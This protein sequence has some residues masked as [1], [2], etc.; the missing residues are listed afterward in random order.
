VLG[1]APFFLIA[2]VAMPPIP[3]ADPQG[4]SQ[5][6]S[7]ERLAHLA[8]GPTANVELCRVLAGEH[9]GTLVAVKRLRPMLADDPDFIAMFRDEMWLASMLRHP[10]IAQVLGWGEDTQGLYLAVEFVR[11]VSLQR[12][13]RTV[14]V[15]GEAFTE[16]LVVYIAAC[17]CAGL[18][19]AHELRSDAGEHLNLVHRDLTPGNL[20]LGFDGEVKITDFGLAKAKQRITQTEVGITK[21]EPQY[22]SP[23]QVRGMPLDGRSDLFALGVVLYELFAQRRPWTVRNVR[24]AL[25]HI[26]RGDAPD[27]A[28]LAPRVDPSLVTLVKRCM[29]KEAD[30]RPASATE[31]L[32]ELEQWLRLHG[33]EKSR[34]SLARFVR[35]NALKQMRW[36]ERAIA[37]DLTGSDE[38]SPFDASRAEAAVISVPDSESNVEI[39]EVTRSTATGRAAVAEPFIADDSVITTM[40]RQAP[41]SVT[42]QRRTGPR[43]RDATPPL[44]AAIAQAIDFG[45]ATSDPP[46]TQSY[47]GR[48]KDPPTL[49]GARAV[50]PLPPAVPPPLVPVPPPPEESSAPVPLIV[51]AS[52]EEDPEDEQD[53]ST[54]RRDQLALELLA[55][56]ERMRTTASELLKRANTAAEEAQRSA[57]AA[58]GAARSAEDLAR[59]VELAVEAVRLAAGAMRSASSGDEEAAS[60]QLRRAEELHD[61][62][63]E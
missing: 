62:A 42:S 5:P 23:E 20:L 19:A 4:L 57:Q 34:Y 54:L 37:G 55:A 40:R 56:A 60:Q 50:G 44:G 61:A 1:L 58:A 2:L 35:R 10:N 15:T 9:R 11:G 8:A 45:D 17:V 30:E 28:E 41:P 18:T 25:E 16:R 29:A 43:K 39:I 14:F 13:M 12:L 6:L 59:R 48:P 53:T 31:L 47:P 3:E 26:V 49:R 22:M 27:L 7:F 36:L 21:G 51:P 33:Y 38:A 24:D 63:R 52:D 46:N 32:T